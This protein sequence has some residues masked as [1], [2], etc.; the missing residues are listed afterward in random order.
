MYILYT[1]A[2]FEF[3]FLGSYDF[4]LLHIHTCVYACTLYCTCTLYIHDACIVGINYH[5]VIACEVFFNAFTC[6]SLAIPTQR[7]SITCDT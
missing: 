5:I 2:E 6:N 7:V 4:Q 1:L 3:R